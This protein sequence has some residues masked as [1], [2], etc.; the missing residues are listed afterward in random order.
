MTELSGTIVISDE[1][2]GSLSEE[3]ITGVTQT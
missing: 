2:A 1:L 3:Y